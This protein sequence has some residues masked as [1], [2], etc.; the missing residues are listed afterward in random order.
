SGNAQGS[1]EEADQINQLV[2]D[3]LQCDYTDRDGVTRRV[4]LDQIIIV[5]P[6]NMQVR[7]IAQRIAG[8]Q[9]ASVDKFQ[10]REGAIVILSMCASEGH[11][12]P[13]GI[14]FLFSKNRLNVAIS[15]ATT[16][17]FVVGSAN[18]LKTP[19]SSLEQM[20]LLNF[21]CQIVEA[22]KQSSK[23][24]TEPVLAPA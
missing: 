5:A 6:Y 18:L 16:L 17:A 14:E 20:R 23:P 22:G 15:R 19:C 1:D 9:V 21:F 7:K 11:S 24:P 4:T 10:G 12:S 8:A 2:N 3:L 13:R